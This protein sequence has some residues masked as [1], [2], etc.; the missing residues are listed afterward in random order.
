VNRRTAVFVA[1]AVLLAI[2]F[3]RLGIWQLSRLEQRRARNRVL[4]ARLAEPPIPFEQL[5][6]TM[7]YRRATL[8]G[9]P[10]Y[11]N[12]LVYTGRSRNGSPG[13]YILTPVRRPNNDTAVLV[14]RGWVYAPDAATA[15]LSRWREPRKTFAGYVSALPARSSPNAARGRKIRVLSAQSVRGSLP[16]AVAAL[17]VVSQDSVSDST[18]ARLPAPALDDGPHLS[19]AIQWF[20]FATIAVVGAAMVVVRDRT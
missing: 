17:Y 1:V 13:V 11:A 12:E 8:A 14:I 4:A 2:V 20:S 9:A 16:Y 19:Y 10:D 3:V 6:D 7:S 15:D 5:R 18:P